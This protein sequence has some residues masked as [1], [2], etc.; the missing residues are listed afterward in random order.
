[1]NVF[2]VGH[3]TN[4][5]EPSPHLGGGVSYTGFATTKLGQPT[6]IITKCSVQSPYIRE[7]S[8]LRIVVNRLPVRESSF[9]YATTAFKNF[10]D[11]NENRH[12]IVPEIQETINLDDLKNFPNIPQDTIILVA[13]VVGEVDTRLF[14][15]LAK[16]GHLVV[17]PQGY[18]RKIENDGTVKHQ[19][20]QNLSALAHA[21]M[22]ILSDEDLTFDEKKGIDMEMFAQIRTLC[23]L[24]V[25]T[26]GTKGATIFERDTGQEIHTGV[27]RLAADEVKDLTGAGDTYAAAFMIRY[28][29]TKNIKEASVFAALYSALKIKSIGGE[30]K[31]MI[32]I[33]TLNQVQA[34]VNDEKT[35]FDEFLKENGLNS[36]PIYHEGNSRFI[37]MK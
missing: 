24:A 12:Q 16:R 33:P 34:F 1:M 15:E 22:V 7:L 21:K 17:T 8:D 11:E 6:A 35:R 18:F 20:W 37:E 2:A 19:P 26:Q 23:P 9:E 25:L 31:G 29:Q 14:P 5:L 4:D 10:Y 27:F 13:T 32:T 28:E 36:L 30:G 3:I